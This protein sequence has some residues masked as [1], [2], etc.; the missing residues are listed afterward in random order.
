MAFSYWWP[1]KIKRHFKKGAI[2]WRPQRERELKESCSVITKKVRIRF[3]A[4]MHVVEKSFKSVARNLQ[5]TSMTQVTPLRPTS[6]TPD[7]KSGFKDRRTL[8]KI[9]WTSWSPP[10]SLLSSASRST[11]NTF[12]GAPGSG[13]RFCANKCLTLGSLMAST[14]V[15]LAAENNKQTSTVI[16]RTSF[17]M[18]WL[19]TAK[20]LSMR[21]I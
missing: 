7:R 4:S 6:L 8:E 11:V 14:C 18:V 17:S 20:W 12:L 1:L 16:S 21:V 5:P 10:A 19:H 13:A 3:S 15:I 9:L 2:C